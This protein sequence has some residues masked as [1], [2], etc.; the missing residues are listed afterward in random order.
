LIDGENSHGAEFGHIVIDYHDDARLC[1]CGQTGHLEA[2][3]SAKSLVLMAEEAL[4]SGR[5]GSFAARVDASEELTPLLLSEEAAA[6]DELAM[7]LILDVAKYL[8]VGIV[9]LL[10]AIDPHGVVLGGAM[11]F[12]GERDPVGRRFIERI[13]Q[14]VRRRAFPVLAERTKIE[15][16]SLGGSAGYIGAAGIA[17]LEHLRNSSPSGADGG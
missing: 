17:R 5:T 3:A 9:T 15:F 14:E 4:A 10:H 1:P 13:R 6:G 8:G 16:A 12:G 7:E 2:Y 11:T